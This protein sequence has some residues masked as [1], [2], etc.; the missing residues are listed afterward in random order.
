M[1]QDDKVRTDVVEGWIKKYGSK[2]G[3]NP[4][5]VKIEY[6]DEDVAIIT[7]IK[8]WMER[9]AMRLKANTLGICFAG[10]FRGVIQN[11][12]FEIAADDL[13][14]FPSGLTFS[15]V[16]IS[17]DLQFTI[18]LIS[19]RCLQGFLHA[20]MEIWTKLVYV[21]KR[22]KIHL[23]EVEMRYQ[24]VYNSLLTVSYENRNNIPPQY[25]KE[26]IRSL[27]RSAVIAAC[28]CLAVDR[29]SSLHVSDESPKEEVGSEDNTVR[30]AVSSG[31]SGRSGNLFG[32]FLELLQKSPVKHLT[33]KQLAA[34]LCIT[35]KYLS[36]ICVK[37]SG[38][39]ASEWIEEY[40]IA[41]IVFYLRSS[42]LSIKEIAAHVG[43]SSP[44]FF[45]KYV[46]ERLH[47]SPQRYRVMLHQERDNEKASKPQ[48][49]KQ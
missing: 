23:S 40:T 3:P 22:F 39:T 48:T 28:I 9:Q 17:P 21:E 2:E 20:N 41:E 43:F 11:E 42:D 34:Q 6:I 49:G 19:D 14:I 29:S 5:N 44:S 12:P 13:F 36:V 4:E 25:H 15:D 24:R 45:G 26:L 38:K 32:R 8:N 35:P 33:V 31:G 16:M 10:K 27:L 47:M 46:R 7:D 37:N 30:P 18:M 1:T